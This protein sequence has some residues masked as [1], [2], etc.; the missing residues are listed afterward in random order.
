MT[1]PSSQETQMGWVQKK[2]KRTE[3]EQATQ[4]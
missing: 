2:E 3:A 4:W 1:R